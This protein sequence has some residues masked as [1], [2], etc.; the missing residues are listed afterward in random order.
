MYVIE[1]APPRL[2]FKTPQIPSNRD[3][4]ATNWGTLGGLGI[5]I[6]LGPSSGWM[7]GWAAG[8][9]GGCQGSATPQREDVLKR[10]AVHSLR[11]ESVIG[12][13]CMYIW[14]QIH[15]Y[16]YIYTCICMSTRISYIY[17]CGFEAFGCPASLLPVRNEEEACLCCWAGSGRRST[18]GSSAK[19]DE[20]Q[21]W[22][23]QFP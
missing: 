9:A 5:Y 1:P 11:F 20:R 4:K 22:L 21:G 13:T 15:M 12:Y 19:W 23:L 3:H 10:F 18:R 2:P 8:P 6:L 17:T 16:I 7:L 14:T